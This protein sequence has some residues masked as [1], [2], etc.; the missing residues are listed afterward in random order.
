MVFPFSF[1]SRPIA[2]VL[3]GGS[4]YGLYRSFDNGVNW[5][6]LGFENQFVGSIEINEL[7]Y[8]YACVYSH[9]AKFQRSLDGGLTWEVLY[10]ALGGNMIKSFPGGV[11]FACIGTNTCAKL[12][13]SVDYGATWEEVFAF[14]PTEYPYAIV[15]KSADTIYVGTTRWTGGGGGVYRSMDG[16]D[17]WENIGLIDH[18]VSSLALNASGD[19]FA[20]TRGHYSL[21]Q[22]GVYVLPEGETE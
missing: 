10:Q 4:A 5:G 8:I 15:I 2:R 19:L 17:T 12:I 6:L 9:G 7:G 22:G 14:F 20:G 3:G 18:Y 1:L 16:G 11:V 21:Y 13:R